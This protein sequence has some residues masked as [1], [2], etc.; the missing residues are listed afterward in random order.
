MK[1]ASFLLIGGM[2]LVASGANA[3]YDAS[4]LRSSWGAYMSKCPTPN[5]TT[6][7]GCL[8]NCDTNSNGK[9]AMIAQEINANGALFCPTYVNSKR[10]TKAER[11]WTLYHWATGMSKGDCVWLCKSGYTGEKCNTKVSDATTCDTT[12][13]KESSYTGKADACK[14]KGF[15]QGYNLTCSTSNAEGNV[16]MFS[17]E[18]YDCNGKRFN[19]DPSTYNQEHDNVL[20]IVGWLSSGHG[21]F[22]QPL[23][24]NAWCGSLKADGDCK[25]IIAPVG[26]KRLLCKDGYKPNSGNTDCVAINQYVC[27]GIKNCSGWDASRFSGSAYKTVVKSG[28]LQY[29]C[30]TDG[31]GFKD[32]PAKDNTCIECKDTDTQRATLSDV[33][34]QC[35]FTDKTVK[36]SVSASG[37]ITTTPL[38][39]ATKTDMVKDYDGAPCWVRESP[40]E[41]KACILEKQPQIIAETGTKSTIVQA[42][43]PIYLKRYTLKR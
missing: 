38:A 12:L 17:S 35:I 22:A 20:G 16:A 5:F 4:G 28:C 2:T 14:E 24:V 3:G 8:S 11:P 6:S 36:V 9:N 23:I 34:G 32:A 37:T 18:Y 26:T 40:T 21:A 27:D 41:Y 42:G 7:N 1:L 39:Q 15:W 29:R 31:Y 10:N 33:N 13:L 19:E 43:K 25:I 30:A